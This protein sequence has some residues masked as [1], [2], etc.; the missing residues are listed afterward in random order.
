MT[1]NILLRYHNIMSRRSLAFRF[2]FK[3]TFVNVD[4][5]VTMWDHY[6]VYF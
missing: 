5:W 6:F 4:N 3:Y 1:D 2:M